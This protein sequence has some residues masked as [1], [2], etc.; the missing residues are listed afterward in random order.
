[1]SRKILTGL[2]TLWLTLKRSCNEGQER[3]TGQWLFPK[4][5]NTAHYR[6]AYGIGAKLKCGKD[7]NL[8]SAD[9]YSASDPGSV[10][11]FSSF[12]QMRSAGMG[13]F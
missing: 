4:P 13:A 1:M 8:W 11:Y 9:V 6:I 2:L 3:K 12:I 7:R 5:Y 10:F